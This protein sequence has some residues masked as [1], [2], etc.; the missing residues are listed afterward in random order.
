[1]EARKASSVSELSSALKRQQKKKT[2]RRRRRRGEWGKMLCIDALQVRT[3]FN[4]GNTDCRDLGCGGAAG[5][6][7]G[8][9]T[10]TFLLPYGGDELVQPG[11]RSWF[12]V[13]MQRRSARSLT[14]SCT[15]PENMCVEKTRER[16]LSGS[17]RPLFSP[18]VCKEDNGALQQPLVLWLLSAG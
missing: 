9:H 14:C 6:D 18:R 13:E 12:L 3:C 17:E 10:Q 11:S 4:K 15:S 2:K 8:N 5:K 7:V 16:I 1:M